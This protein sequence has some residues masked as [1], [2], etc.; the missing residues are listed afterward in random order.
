METVLRGL[1]GER[2]L[3]YLDDIV[4]WGRTVDE[5]SMNLDQVL[6]RLLDVRLQIRGEKCQFFKPEIG[7]LGHIVSKEGVSTSP[8]KIAAFKEWPIHKNIMEV[9]SFHGFCSYYKSFIKNFAKI[10]HPL[11]QL[12]HR[13]VTFHWSN[14]CQKAFEELRNA[15]VTSPVLAYPWP[16]GQVILDTDASEKGL[17]AVLSQVREGSPLLS[18]S[19]LASWGGLRVTVEQTNDEMCNEFAAG[20]EAGQRP[21]KVGAGLVAE[22][23]KFWPEFPRLIIVNCDYQSLVIS[24]YV[25][26]MLLPNS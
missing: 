5:C 6:K 4:V 17:G 14:E 1:L 12:M 22:R 15:L 7:Y 19:C 16:E 9:R 2:A 24:V 10:A 18:V 13:E 8:S 20:V 26:T 25:I 21:P 11:T 23:R 3:V